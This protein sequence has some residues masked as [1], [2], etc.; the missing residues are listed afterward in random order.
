MQQAG[1]VELAKP[2]RQQAG[3]SESRYQKSEA[4]H[5]AERPER[6]RHRRPVLARHGV[7]TFKRRIERMLQDQGAQMRNLDRVFDLSRLLVGQTEQDQRRAVRMALVM[8]FHRHD[9]GGLMLERIE[10]LLIA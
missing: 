7:E 1:L 3:E 10:A 6:D 4:H 9:L 2:A 5:D 8:A